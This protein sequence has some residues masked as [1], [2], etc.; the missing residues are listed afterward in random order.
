M[1]VRITK[2]MRES[3]ASD[4]IKHRFAQAVKDLCDMRAA[5][6]LEVYRDIYTVE[7]RE[8][9]ARAPAG[10]L[11]TATQLHAK[12]GTAYT[13]VYFDG[14]VYGIL[15]TVCPSREV[16]SRPIFHSH[17]SNP[18][19]VYEAGDL[20]T[21]RHE[22]VGHKTDDLAKVVGD[23]RRAALAAISSSTTI[24]ALVKAWPEIAPFTKRFAAKDRNLP[25]VNTAKLNEI[26]DLPVSV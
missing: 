17:T 23:A 22:L 7:Q 1:S 16:I 2:E 13:P 3:L 21:V 12:F 24:D 15:S 20:L 8:F 4:L 18:A 5:H 6:A 14:H 25:A 26:L 19:K 11:V 10:M 9:M